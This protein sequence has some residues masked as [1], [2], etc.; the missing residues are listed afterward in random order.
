MRLLYCI[1]SL[2]TGGAERQTSYLVESMQKRGHEVHVAF[3]AGGPNLE[4]IARSGA[5]LHELGSRGNYDPRIFL[6]LLSLI[7]RIR[8]DVVQ[9]C[10]TQMDV[11][12]GLASVVGGAP[13]V[14]REP[15]ALRS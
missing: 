11:A 10:L 5:T 13:W 3:T 7:R 15:S 4:R 9:T 1:S 12:G 8:P 2:A 6:R 14:L